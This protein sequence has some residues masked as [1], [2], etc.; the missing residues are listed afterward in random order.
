MGWIRAHLSFAILQD[1]MICVRGSTVKWRSLGI[2][3]GAS[4]KKCFDY[5][6][7]D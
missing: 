4:I 5:F 3:D 2:V 7:I 1:T 6:L